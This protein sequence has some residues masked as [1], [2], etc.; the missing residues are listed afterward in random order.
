MI[1]EIGTFQFAFVTLARDGH[2]YL[3]ATDVVQPAVSSYEINSDGS[4]RT[5]SQFVS[6]EGQFA[7]CWIAGSGNF[8]Y[9]ANLGSDSISSFRAH[10]DFSLS[11]VQSQAA[12]RFGGAPLDL[13]A[14]D[15]FLYQLFP[16][17]GTIG[18]YELDQDGAMAFIGEFGGL[19][20]F[21]NDIF[22]TPVGMA[23]VLRI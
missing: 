1:T 6:T 21:G 19:E 15:E 16:G 17:T 7:P 20:P 12:F 8:V 13:I 23:V 22:G 10:E 2:N 4:L 11:L 18:V 9:S 14:T 5:I 3:V